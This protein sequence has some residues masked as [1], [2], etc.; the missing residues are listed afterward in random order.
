MEV[1]SGRWG[2]T[3]AELQV[4]QFLPTYLSIHKIAER[5]YGSTN[6][7]KT[8]ARAVYRKLDVS[9]RAEA[10]ERARQAGLLDPES[11]SSEVG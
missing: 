6:T 1:A 2:L 3:P 7:V 8:Q 10:V 5:L 9:S 11:P 4:L